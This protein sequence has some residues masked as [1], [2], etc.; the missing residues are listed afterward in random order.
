MGLAAIVL[1]ITCASDDNR[2]GQKQIADCLQMFIS[3]HQHI[4]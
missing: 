1:D 4:H 3:S 2:Q